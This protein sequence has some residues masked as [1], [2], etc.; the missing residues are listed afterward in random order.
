MWDAEFDYGGSLVTRVGHGSVAVPGALAGLSAAAERYGTLPW[1]VLCEPIIEIAERG[2]PLP[3]ASRYYLEGAGDVIYGWHQESYEALHDGDRLLEAG[4]NVII[5]GFADAMRHIATA[6]ADTLYRGDLAKLLVGEMEA[7]G[8]LI[9]AED[10]DQYEVF[11]RQPYIE[12]VNGWHMATNPAPAVGGATLLALVHLLE[13]PPLVDW[14]PAA[15]ARFVH[16]QE[17][18]LGYRRNQLDTACGRRAFR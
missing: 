10:L 14:D 12:N 5:P 17:F 3:T 11:L 4:E 9:T 18:V 2:Y 8:G 13:D 1:S 15:L 16:I 7:G 6:G